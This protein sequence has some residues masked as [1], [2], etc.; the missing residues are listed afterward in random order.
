MREYAREQ[1]LEDYGAEV[2]EKIEQA[3]YDGNMLLVYS[4]DNVFEI[5]G[6]ILTNHSMSVDDALEL[7]GVDMD[8]WAE[9]KGWEGWDWEALELL[10]VE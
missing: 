4:D 1:I 8:A 2:L 9:G 5:I 10:D 7:L 6:G 3:E